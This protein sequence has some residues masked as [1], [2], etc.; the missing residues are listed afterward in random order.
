MPGEGWPLI[1][2]FAVA[3]ANFNFGGTA[4]CFSI[5]GLAFGALQ[6]NRCW[7]F[8]IVAFLAPC[9][10]HGVNMI[11]DWRHDGTS[12]NLFPLEFLFYGITASPVFIGTLL[13]L[14]VRR[15]LERSRVNPF[16]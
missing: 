14:L 16:S 15:F 1:P 7:L 11:N 10:L 3:W 13:G 6:P 2:W 8:A 5:L 12:H 9:V 4:I